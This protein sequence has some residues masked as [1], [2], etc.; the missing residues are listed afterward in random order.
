MIRQPAVW[1]QIG[2]L[3]A[4]AQFLCN[5][6][7]SVSGTLADILSPA[8]MV[9]FGTLLTTLNKPMFAL[10]GYVY[11][12]FGTVATLYWITAGTLQE[13]T[14]D[15]CICPACLHPDSPPLKERAIRRGIYVFHA[16]KAFFYSMC[17]S[18]S[19]SSNS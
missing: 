16:L 9:I 7:K 12:A 17:L 4:I 18:A 19:C 3:Q 15:S 8:K 14:Y 6:S 13:P 2:N 11:A 5:A 10:S 1:L